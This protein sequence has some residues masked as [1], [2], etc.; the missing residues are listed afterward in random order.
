MTGP[1]PVNNTCGGGGATA[2][3]PTT[4]KCPIDVYTPLKNAGFDPTQPDLQLDVL[5]TPGAAGSCVGVI[6]PGLLTVAN[7]VSSCPGNHNANG[8]A[9][10]AAT[11]YSACDQDYHCD[12]V[13][14]SPTYQTCIWNNKP[15][16]PW[17]DPNCVVGSKLGFD[18]TIEPG[19]TNA[20]GGNVS[21]P[22][23]NR[24]G[25]TIPAG[26]TITI[27]ISNYSGGCGGTACSA[28]GGADCSYVL[29][30]PLT[31]GACINIP[32][33]PAAGLSPAGGCN[34]GAGDRCLQVNQGNTVTDVNGNKECNTTASGGTWPVNGTGAGCQDNDTYVK[35]SPAGCEV[36]N[37]PLSGGGGGSPTLASWNVTYSCVPSE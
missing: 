7:G 16:V 31:A 34:L 27:T 32:P 10:T 22:V 6:S 33:G 12:L 9:C 13:T 28:G 14:G 30:A 25:A 4:G 24:G 17:I 1:S 35:N 26:Q 2:C 11:Q 19:C 20:A 15:P 23:C 8:G 29:P 36:C 3:T 18:L 37:P 21:I 5:L